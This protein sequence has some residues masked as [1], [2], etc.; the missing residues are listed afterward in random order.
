V[1]IGRPAKSARG[2]LLPQG[3]GEFG[4]QLRSRAV[5][6]PGRL[7]QRVEAPAAELLQP[8]LDAGA[9]P[10]QVGGHFLEVQL[11]FQAELD[12]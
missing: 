7:E 12:G 10:A 8:A 6:P 1:G 2:H 3:F 5:A 9:G 11:A 4:R